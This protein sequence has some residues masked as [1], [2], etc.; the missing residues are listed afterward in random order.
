M[1]NINF[2]EILSMSKKDFNEKYKMTSCGWRGKS[3]LQRNVLI[4]LAHMK[5]LDDGKKFNSPYVKEYYNKLL[6]NSK[7]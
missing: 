4:N 5:K 7:F 3:V 1:R 6:K 2:E